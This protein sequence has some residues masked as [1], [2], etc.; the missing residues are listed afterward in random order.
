[1]LDTL[2]PVDL[3]EE[4]LRT[5]AAGIL[6]MEGRE[7]LITLQSNLFALGLESLSVIELLTQ[8]EDSFEVTVDVEDLGDDVF[9]NFAGLVRFVK[10]LQAR[11]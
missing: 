2:A 3:V 7:E 5:I 1:M 6:H 10:T 11:G 9:E 4:R 8:I